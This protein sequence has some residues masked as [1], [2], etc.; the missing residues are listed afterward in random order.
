MV[1][2]AAANR[3]SRE[4]SSRRR[5]SSFWRREH[6]RPRQQRRSAMGSAPQAMGSAPQAL[7]TAAAEVERRAGRDAVG[8]GDLTFPGPTQP[9]PAE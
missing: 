7:G 2:L 4:N 3:V 1:V 5:G 6:L 9:I 8:G